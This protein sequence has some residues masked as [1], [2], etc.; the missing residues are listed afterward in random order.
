M[1]L[2]NGSSKHFGVARTIVTGEANLKNKIKIYQQ[3][4]GQLGL[5]KIKKN[6]SVK[7]AM[8]IST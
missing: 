7:S 4:R 5:D 6:N 8:S 1:E 2:H 3:S